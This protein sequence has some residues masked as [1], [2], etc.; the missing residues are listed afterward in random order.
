MNGKYSIKDLENLTG[1]K[2]HTLR[3]WEQRYGL[4][5][6]QRT[7]TNIRLYSDD[8]LKKLLNVAVL[9]HAG[10]KISAV[11][12][13]EPAALHAAVQT[14]ALEEAE[15]ESQISSLKRAMLDFDESSFTGVLEQ[16]FR[17]IG[18]GDTFTGLVAGFI[19]TIGTLWQTDAI[20]VAQEHFAS[21]LIKQKLYAA[22]DALAIPQPA[23]GEGYT[24]LYLP[25]EELHELGLLYLHYYLKFK[26]VPTLFLGQSVPLMY[27]KDALT[28]VPVR[29]VVSVFTTCPTRDDL[30]SYVHELRSLVPPQASIHLTG[31]QLND[32]LSGPEWPSGVHIHPH[33]GALKESV[34]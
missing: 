8:D 21:N 7:D 30:R 17:Q 3:I 23:P 6:P 15:Y 29:Q 14:A 28:S 33:L 4:V 13:M 26:G 10:H 31:L 22:L 9:V 20:S 34:V 1:I 12:S 25:E 5:E 16:S 2:A 32:A 24:L 18:E 27:L 11:A 19:Y